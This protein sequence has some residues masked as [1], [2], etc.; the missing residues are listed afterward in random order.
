MLA[1]KKGALHETQPGNEYPNAYLT[2]DTLGS[3]HSRAESDILTIVEGSANYFEAE[4]SLKTVGFPWRAVIQVV[5]KHVATPVSNT[6]LCCPT[7]CCRK[8]FLPRPSICHCKFDHRAC[9]NASQPATLPTA[10]PASA[11]P[12]GAGRH[13]RCHP[14]WDGYR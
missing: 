12:A 1:P 6:R 2:S 4:N 7:A 8:S 13:E 10:D 11:S 14:A 9:V 3:P 5:S